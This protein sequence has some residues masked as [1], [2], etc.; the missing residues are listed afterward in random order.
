MRHATSSDTF[1]PPPL[2]T[3]HDED[4]RDSVSRLL[5]LLHQ[6]VD[7]PQDAALALSSALDGF[8]R[9]P[10]FALDEQTSG[11]LVAALMRAQLV[12]VRQ[13]AGVIGADGMRRG[14]EAFAALILRR[15][16]SAFRENA[17]RD[18]DWR[19]SARILQNDLHNCC[20]LE[21]IERR[22]T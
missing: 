4:A 5:D 9:W 19:D 22:E 20:L 13:L 16:H 11:Q 14:M 18:S 21:A 12:A 1:N 7:H 6:A 15:H 10:M 17:D 3:D 2:C 8:R